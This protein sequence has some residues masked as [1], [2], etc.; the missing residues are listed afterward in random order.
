M[1]Q[2][3]D[4][5]FPEFPA[6]STTEWEAKII[7]GLKGAD[8]QKKLIWKTN[9]GFDIKPYYRVEDLTGLEYLDTNPGKYPFVRG[10]DTKANIWEIRQDMDSS[11]PEK[12]NAQAVDA[13]R[14][15]ATGISFGAAMIKTVSD[16]ETLLKGICVGETGCHF[17]AATSYPDLIRLMGEFAGKHHLNA[18]V[19]KGSFDF[20][21]ISYLLLEGEFWISEEFDMGQVAEMVKLGKKLLPSMKVITV[22]GQYFHNCGSTMVQELAFSL[23]AGNEYLAASTGKGLSIDDVAPRIVFSLAIGSD[24][25]MEIAKLRAARLLWARIVEQYKPANESSML[26]NIHCSTSNFNKSLFDPYVNLLRTTTESMSA[27]LGGTQSLSVIP[28]DAFYKDPD[29]ISTRIARNQQI[30]L[31]EETYLEH[32]VDPA[33]G[34]YYI[35][36]LTDTIAKTAWDLFK[37]VEEMGGM[38]AAVKAG[39]IQEEVEKQA[40]QR[41]L[42]VATRKTIVLGTNQYPNVHEMM[43]EKIQE[44]IDLSEESEAEEKGENEKS[45]TYKKLEI[46][47]ATDDFDDLRLATE[48]YV[49]EGGKRPSVFLLTMGNLA[50]RKARAMFSTNFFGCA[51]YNVIDKEGFATT[52]E[53]V[54]DALA[55]KSEIIVICSS[56]EEYAV[57][58]PEITMALKGKN[59]DVQVVVAGFPKD[60]VEQLKAVG[61]DEFIHIRT[62]VL[63]TLTRFQEKL[64][65]L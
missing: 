46:I 5:L 9:E 50:M 59:K 58:T 45:T 65:I 53:G 33:A 26:M 60:I 37:K 41:K 38:L 13:L 51:G 54:K 40:I 18:S 17:G 23:A 31:K 3:N 62:N 8:Y 19:I 22:N 42:D 43:L 1:D 35:E 44:A 12:A 15:G 61:V 20:D 10:S 47:R 24:Y 49:E 39:Y 21:P 29:E 25:F 11:D 27:V 2:K 7:E 64:G 16:L 55:S 48:V 63:E 14:R 52:S 28:F 30:I 34:S 6:V 56:D 4:K 32:V 36:N 57:I